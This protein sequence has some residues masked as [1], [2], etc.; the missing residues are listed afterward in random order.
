[1]SEKSIKLPNVTLIAV[2]G[3]HIEAHQKALNVS[4]EKIEFG[5]V[6]LVEKHFN[7]IDDWNNY[8]LYN[9]T[10]HVDTD[11]CILIHADG[12]IIN[13]ELWR[14]E[15]LEFDYIGA[16]WPLPK[17]NFSYR[18]SK[19]EL[20]RVGNSVGLRSKK[21]LDMPKKLGLEFKDFHGN[22]NEDGKLCVEWRDILKDNGIKFAPLEVAV[23]FSKEHTIPE[24]EGLQTFMFHKYGY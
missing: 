12:Y 4:C 22:T 3:R 9:L 8:I 11:Y 24:N 18:T 14:D 21:I 17:D 10:D 15:W 20:I 1:M 23:H 2:T 16:P 13:P 5:A 6:K 19:G 7:T